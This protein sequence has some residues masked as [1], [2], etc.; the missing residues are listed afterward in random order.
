MGVVKV[1]SDF[2]RE[3]LDGDATSTEAHATLVR[4]GEAL[5][6]E[7]DRFFAASLDVPQNVATALAV[8]DGAGEPLTPSQIGQRMVVSSATMTSTLDVLEHKGWIRRTPNPEDRRSLLI[9][10]TPEGQ[11]TADQFLPGVRTIERQAM[12][13]LTKKER[14]MLLDMLGRILER[15]AETAEA[16]PVPL[17]G[18]RV[19][20][21]RLR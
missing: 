14:V 16:D 7:L 15:V 8:L 4:T 5:L 19:R 3:Y 10:I 2:D 13:G 1:D 21:D 6:N 18:R 12:A 9:E 20:P 11:R 17:G